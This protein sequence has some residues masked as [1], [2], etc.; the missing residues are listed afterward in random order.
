MKKIK[1]TNSKQRFQDSLTN[2]LAEPVT[3]NDNQYGA[4]VD[5][6]FNIGSG[7]MAK[8]DLVKRMNKGED[9]VNVANEE[10]P[11]WNKANGKVSN[12]LV[13]R[14][15]ADIDLFNAPAKLP[16]LPAKC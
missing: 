1:N 5:W 2:A 13:R 3:L 10:L 7:N 14:R 11:Q 6:T 15:K 8:S 16:A 4:L 12:G 9:V